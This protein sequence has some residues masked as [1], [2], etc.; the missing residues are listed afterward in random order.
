V[1][2]NTNQANITGCCRKNRES[3]GK[4]PIT[5]EKLR[6]MYYKDYIKDKNSK[7]S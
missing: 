5:G 1:Q 7:A 6:W 3:A 2:Y 4:H